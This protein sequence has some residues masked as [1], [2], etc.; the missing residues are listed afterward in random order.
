MPPPCVRDPADGHAPAAVTPVGSAGQLV[1]SAYERL[2]AAGCPSPRLDAELLVGDALGMS[3]T[4]LIVHHERALAPGEE[5]LV[6]ERISRRA[7]AEPVAYILGRR[8]FRQLDLQV[9][10]RV[11]VPRPE[12][13]A[14]VDQALGLPPGAR[15]HDVGTGSG[16]VALALKHE[17]P[18]LVVSGSDPDPNALR[19]ARANASRLRLDVEWVE[20][21]GL[22]AGSYDLVL[23]NL[24]YVA[25]GEWAS[26]PPD[27]T[28]HEPRSAL[29]GGPDGLDPIR[30]LVGQ[31]PS[32]QRLALEHGSTQGAAVRALL[33]DARTLPDLAGHPRVTSGRAR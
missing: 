29:L 5:S 33:S 28:G 9:D 8:Y 2:R 4:A 31:A 23:A 32:G 13:E 3:R 17:R 22:P 24:P 7:A 20:Q 25:D 12:T 1:R 21:V 6:E 10:P 16:A 15:V 30:A 14:L 18:D 27:I 26:L 11:L 19:V